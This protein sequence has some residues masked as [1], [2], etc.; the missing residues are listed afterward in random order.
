MTISDILMV[1]VMMVVSVITATMCTNAGM[2]PMATTVIT[3]L[4]GVAAP[5][6]IT[7]RLEDRRLR[8]EID[9]SWYRELAETR[10]RDCR[11]R[12]AIDAAMGDHRISVAEAL[13]IERSIRRLALVDA[14]RSAE[15]GS[16]PACAVPDETSSRE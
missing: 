15:G 7:E 3:L 10:R 12:P 6:A 9:A 5:Y 14:R 16:M 1:A 2:R 4:I 13:P 11:V 8:S